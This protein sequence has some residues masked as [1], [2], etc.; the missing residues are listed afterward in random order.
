V[1]TI[2]ITSTHHLG[3]AAASVR[4][5]SGRLL[6]DGLT[7]T[8]PPEWAA[9]WVTIVALVLGVA[10]LLFVASVRLLARVFGPLAR[11]FEIVAALGQA[12]LLAA[13]VTVA[14]LLLL[15]G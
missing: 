8:P 12:A 4:L 5:P 15:A 10:L 7:I 14:L 13:V 9:H 6:P 1:T 2:P 3:D 11:L